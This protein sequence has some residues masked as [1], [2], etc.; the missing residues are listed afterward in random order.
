MG[1][2]LF[3]QMYDDALA[4]DC[5]AMLTFLDLVTPSQA[6][7]QSF[8]RGFWE[9]MPVDVIMDKA[10]GLV[11]IGDEFLSSMKKLLVEGATSVLA[12][13]PHT[14]QVVRIRDPDVID[15]DEPA[16]TPAGFFHLM[17]TVPDQLESLYAEFCSGDQNA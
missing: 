7:R 13:N 12:L 15:F 14:G 3:Q 9:S 8:G 6:D 11:L 2:V 4:V 16:V 1:Q 5:R 17:M 10:R